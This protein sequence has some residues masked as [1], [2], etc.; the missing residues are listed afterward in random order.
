M[1]AVLL[2]IFLAILAAAASL[3]MAG[4]LAGLALTQ[5]LRKRLLGSR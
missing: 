3:F 4:F 5:H 1:H 2:T